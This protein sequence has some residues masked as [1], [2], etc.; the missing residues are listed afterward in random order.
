MG[1]EEIIV[2]DD[3]SA[4]YLKDEEILVTTKSA[5]AGKSIPTPT[6]PEVKTTHNNSTDKIAKWGDDNLFPQTVVKESEETF[7]PTVLDW[8]ARALYSGGIEYGFTTI[9]ENGEEVFF[10]QKLPLVEDFL[11]KSNIKKYLLE[12]CTDFYWF[13]N[14]FPEIIVSRDR[15]TITGITV[16]EASNCRWG[17]QNTSNGMIEKCFINANWAEMEDEN[18]RFTSIVPVI[19]PYYDP[20]NAL[21]ERSDGNKFI[22]PL[23]YPTPG[24]TYYQLAHWN[25]IRKSGWLDVSRSIASFKK[26]LLKN[27]LTIKYHIEVADYWWKEKYPNWDKLSPVEKNKLKTAELESFNKFLKGAERAGTS[28]MTGFKFDPHINREYPGWKIHAIDD[29]VKSG[30]YIEDSQEASAHMLYALGV[31]GTLIGNAPGKGMGAGSGSDK[32]VAFNVYISLCEPHK[33]IVLEPLYFSSAYNGYSEI[34]KKELQGRPLEWRL[35]KTSITTLDK[36]KET[37]QQT[38]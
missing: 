29:K 13:Y 28:L 26:H 4:F 12:A 3:Y 21:K 16:Q 8:K 23:S 34:Y 27:Q 22:Y 1:K 36:G 35:K 9:K 30:I 17:L 25:S 33:D 7:I 24:K 37:Q 32:R 6:T 5:A 19:D 15:K 14:V 10:P 11:F 31:D 38:S 2:N 18:S 20:V